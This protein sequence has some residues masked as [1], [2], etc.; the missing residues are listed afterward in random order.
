MNVNDSTITE[1]KREQIIGFVEFYSSHFTIKLPNENIVSLNIYRDSVMYYEEKDSSDNILFYGTLV[2]DKNILHVTPI[3]FPVE[4]DD[5]KE[6]WINDTTYYWVLDGVC[7]E[8]LE[9]GITKIS[10]FDNGDKVSEYIRLRGNLRD[11]VDLEVPKNKYYI[12]TKTSKYRFAQP[13]RDVL[14]KLIIGEWYHPKSYTQQ[15]FW[16]F[17][18]KKPSVIEDKGRTH[19]TFKKNMQFEGKRKFNCGVGLT[20]DD[21][22]PKGNWKI[23]DTGKLKIGTHLYEI[24]YIDENTMFLKY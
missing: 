4:T 15:A 24:V 17:T 9:Q 7:R 5:G 11:V 21:Y 23:T 22:Y 12:D 14:K 18:K 16:I 19:T 3:E 1:I 2:I 10:V 6:L 20:K 8:P 13:K